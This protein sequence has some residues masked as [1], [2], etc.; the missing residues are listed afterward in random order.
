VKTAN[1]TPSYTIVGTVQILIILVVSVLTNVILIDR[2][3][4]GIS[5][6]MKT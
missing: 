4:S 1:L 3:G 6:D 2:E 5:H